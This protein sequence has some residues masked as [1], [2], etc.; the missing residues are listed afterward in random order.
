[1]NYEDY[2][3][4][5][6]LNDLV[7]EIRPFKPKNIELI[8]DIDP[9]IPSVMNTDI[10]KLRKILRHLI[11]NGLKYTHEG[12]VYVRISSEKE[13]YGVNLFIEVTDT[14]IGMTEEETE[15]ISERFYQAD[16]GRSRKGGGLGL[17]MSIVSGFVASLGGFIT[18][19]SRPGAGTTVTV[20][21]PQDVI[22][23][24]GCMSVVDPNKLCLGAFLHF[25][26]FHDPN[27]R[28]Y[29][30]NMVRNIVNGL[31][32]QMH[33]VDNIGNLEK[34]LD[35]VK[36]T[37]LFVGEDE[38]LASSEQLEKLTSEMTVVV[39]ANEDIVLPPGARAKIMS[40]PFYC[41]PVTTVL[42]AG[43][44]QPSEAE[45]GNMYCR[46][47]TAL[48]VDDEPMNLTVA[49]NIFKRYGM[50]VSTAMSGQESIDMCRERD[51]DI[52]FMDHMMPGMDGVTA[53]KHLRADKAKEHR[54]I[55]IVAL[56]ANAVSTAKEMF[57]SEG[58]DG[59]VSKPIELV[60]LERVMKRVLPSSVITYGDDENEK[61]AAA[62]E[63]APQNITPSAEHPSAT[64]AS[65][66]DTSD[67]TEKKPVDVVFDIPA[68]EGL[69]SGSTAENP[70]DVYGA[71]KALGIDTDMGLDYCLSDGEFYK[72][73]LM[74]FADESDEKRGKMIK[75]FEEKDYENYKILVHAL[76]ST[77]KMIGD[78]ELS[79]KAKALEYAAKE[80]RPEYIIENHESVMNE[81]RMLTDG[82]YRA[83]GI[84]HGSGSG[85]VM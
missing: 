8:I 21:L 55:T 52:V 12:G 40:K 23:P 74:Q 62:P 32:V 36:L 20:S 66:D 82:I 73:L 67:K 41:F 75:C 57:L 81:Y 71:L 47:V 28:E 11:I 5:S 37:H 1:N 84:T 63:A 70:D 53:M 59:F 15:R 27:V 45:R 69:A 64:V 6:V 56:T 54:G 30:N 51:F 2:M 35:S 48:V 38:Y 3:L 43:F 77:S 25:D 19:K 44:E 13:P 83:Y 17:G 60:E 79:E 46:G 16:S 78:I 42:N 49:K 76:K 22:D 85:E 33:R 29:Y 50:I 65:N 7:A 24:A 10:S 61:K 31:G 18:I 80:N 72:S 14:G 34:L 4:A 39:V 26:K 9:A 58:F 68:G